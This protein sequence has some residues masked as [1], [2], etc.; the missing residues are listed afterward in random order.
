MSCFK[1]IS[2]DLS[3]VVAS[4]LDILDMKLINDTEMRNVQIKTPHTRHNTKDMVP[5]VF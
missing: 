5:D 2:I 4:S 1:Y 3:L